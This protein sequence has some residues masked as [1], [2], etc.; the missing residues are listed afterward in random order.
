MRLG[1]SFGLG[2][3]RMYFPLNSRGRYWRHGSCS[4][5]HRTKG[6]ADRCKETR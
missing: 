1:L 2:P 3:L 4:I 5:R 6:A